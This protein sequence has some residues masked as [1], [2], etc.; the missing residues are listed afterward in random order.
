MIKISFDWHKQLRLML[1]MILRRSVEIICKL[2]YL[3]IYAV[4]LKG[5]IL[6]NTAI[7]VI[8]LRDKEIQTA[9]LSIS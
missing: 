4:S 5:E 7:R 9:Y 1:L 3:R 2:G 6:G 8:L